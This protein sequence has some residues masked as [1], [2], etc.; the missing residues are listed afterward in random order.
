MYAAGAT[1]TPW[2]ARSA[3]RFGDINTDDTAVLY[4]FWVAVLDPLGLSE[5]TLRRIADASFD[6]EV[7]LPAWLPPTIGFH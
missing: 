7:V 1:T 4:E 2:T 5:A 6:L 3:A